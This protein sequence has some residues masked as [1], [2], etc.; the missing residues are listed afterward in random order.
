MPLNMSG[1]WFNAVS[2]G[3]NGEEEIDYD[4]MERKAHEANQSIIAGPAYHAFD[5]RRKDVGA[6]FLVDMA[7]YS[8]R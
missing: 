4:A 7:H 3:L 2:S 8:T 5:Q 1:K 6:I